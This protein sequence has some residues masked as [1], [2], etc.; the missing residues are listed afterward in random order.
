MRRRSRLGTAGL[1]R[2]HYAAGLRASLLVAL[3]VGVTVAGVSLA[4]RALARL[5]D[6][7]LQHALTTATVTELDLAGV[8][9]P[10]YPAS[11]ASQQ[12]AATDIAIRNVRLGV[13]E[14]LRDLVGEAHWVARSS[15]SGA[16]APRGQDLLLSLRLAID[17]SWEDVV[18][19]VEG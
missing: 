18:R 19:P 13:P 6:Q 7:E 5:G 10:G 14:P 3:L 2:R 16:T 12:N 8:G 15:A 4:P 9:Q 17:L 11:G 1:L